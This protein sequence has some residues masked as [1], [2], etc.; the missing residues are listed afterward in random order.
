NGA[1]NG[2]WKFY[3]KQQHLSFSG[4]YINNQKT[5]YWHEYKS[6]LISSEGHY[7]NN[8]KTDWWTCHNKKRYRTIKK[9]FKKGLQHGY[10]LYY[11]KSSLSMVEEYESSKKIGAWTSYF[12]F[13]RDHPGFSMSDLR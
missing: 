13:K 8:L 10:A 11:K 7:T 6:G 9:Q 12:K 5:G 3:D 2:Y 4:H 1:K